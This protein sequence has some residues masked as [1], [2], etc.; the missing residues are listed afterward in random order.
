M[1]F[2]SPDFCRKFYFSHIRLP[3]LSVG[4]SYQIFHLRKLQM[5]FTSFHFNIKIQSREYFSK[6]SSYFSHADMPR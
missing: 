4:E 2:H 5:L 6:S 1:I 3:P